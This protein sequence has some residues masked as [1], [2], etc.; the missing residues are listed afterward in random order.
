MNNEKK[1]KL[2]WQLLRI[3]IAVIFIYAG[4]IK[5]A[6]PAGFAEQVDN[7]RI[8]PYFF[9][10]LVAVVLPWLELLCGILILVNR[11]FSVSVLI[12]SILNFIFIIAII[13]ALIRGLDISCGCF[14]VNE[15]S[16][17]IGIFKLIED[18]VLFGIILL[19]FRFSL[20][21]I[22]EAKSLP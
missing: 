2:L 8:L 7:Y 13:S 21:N 1:R 6:D 22:Q 17:K 12:L 10:T 4:T 16:A 18:I 14:S 3:F 5:I 9:V 20:K 15:Q 11:L 19:L